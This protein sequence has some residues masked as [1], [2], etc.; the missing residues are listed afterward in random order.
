MPV[1]FPPG[2]IDGLAPVGEEQI[3]ALAQKR[4]IGEVLLQGRKDRGLDLIDRDAAGRATGPCLV[5][6]LH[7][8]YP[9][10]R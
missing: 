2:L 4:R 7:R 8:T 10:P 9:L 3:H 5:A 6:R 1:P